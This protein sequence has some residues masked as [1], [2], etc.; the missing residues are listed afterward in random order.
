MIERLLDRVSQLCL[1]LSCIALVLLVIIFGWLVFG[2][3]V[4]N[5]TPT[6]VEQLAL[7]LVVYITFLGAAAGVHED[8]HL[9]V[10]FVREA[11]PV[12]L[13]NAL[14]IIG[15]IALTAF[16]AVMLV[17]CIELVEFGWNTKLPMLNVPE[18]FRT[19]PAALCGGLMMLFAGN[20]ALR[21]LH[22]YYITGVSDDI[23][24][25]SEPQNE[26]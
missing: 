14:R 8:T 18:S 6:W 21:R 19:L 10:T 11:M 25:P 12:W 9:G 24:N 13:R 7:L 26:P 23:A 2:R 5:D 3:Y 15:D 17:S 4:L 22:R 16:G 20:R 1:F